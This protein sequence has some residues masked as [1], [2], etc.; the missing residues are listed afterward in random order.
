MPLGPFFFTTKNACGSRDDLTKLSTYQKILETSFVP[1]K[2]PA[3]ARE[4]R[5]SSD[6]VSRDYVSKASTRVRKHLGDHWVNKK[7]LLG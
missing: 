7:K 2:K 5:Q 4:L 3:V 1:K 6:D